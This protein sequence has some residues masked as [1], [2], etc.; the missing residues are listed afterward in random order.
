MVSKARVDLPDP[1]TPVTTMSLSRGS[2]RVMF[3]RLCW[4]APFM[5]RFFIAGTSC[6]AGVIELRDTAL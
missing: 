2:S 5:T 4:R 3:C 6:A 1:E